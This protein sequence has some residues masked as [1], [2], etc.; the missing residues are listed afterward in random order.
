MT[1]DQVKHE[2]NKKIIREKAQAYKRLFQSDDGKEVLA[3]LE[4]ICGAN[5]TSI[6]SE[7][8][9]NRTFYHEG[10]RNVF[11]HIN[12]KVNFIEREIT[13]E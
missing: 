11:L 3:D 2:K 10:M 1:E 9:A 4:Y 8:N 6:D 5:A 13:N 12:N 7:W